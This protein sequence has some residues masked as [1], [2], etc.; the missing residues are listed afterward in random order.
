MS[1]SGKPYKGQ[2]IWLSMKVFVNPVVAALPE[3][4]HLF[5]EFGCYGGRGDGNIQH[6]ECGT[7]KEGDKETP[8]DK[9]MY[10]LKLTPEMDQK[11]ETMIKKHIK[12]AV[13]SA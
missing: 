13:T 3:H 8:L 7:G 2:H 9:S 12:P 1:P 10:P 11:W 4:A 6:R 5:P